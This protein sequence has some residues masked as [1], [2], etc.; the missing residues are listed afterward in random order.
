ML[1]QAL[2]QNGLVAILRGL[3]PEEAPA[4]GDVLYQAGFRVIEV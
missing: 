1:K 3:R 2:A 4:I